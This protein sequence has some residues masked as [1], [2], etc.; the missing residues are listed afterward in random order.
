MTINPTTIQKRLEAF[1]KKWPADTPF[2]RVNFANTMSIPIGTASALCSQAVVL[3]LLVHNN[4]RPRKYSFPKVEQQTPPSIDELLNIVADID[5]RGVKRSTLAP[6][7]RWI[8]TALE[9]P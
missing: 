9:T 8:A 7:L 1:R 3:G 5:A 4:G 6:L 2:T